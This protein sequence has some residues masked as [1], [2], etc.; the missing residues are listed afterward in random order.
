MARSTKTIVLLSLALLMIS[1]GTNPVTARPSHDSGSD[2]CIS[3]QAPAGVDLGDGDD[4]DMNVMMRPA[5]D[6]GEIYGVQTST[7]AKIGDDD[8]DDVNI[9]ILNSLL[10]PLFRILA[11]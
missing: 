11:A 2:I 9:I 1:I 7:R 8:D 3:A 4:D 6:G 5:D 10:V